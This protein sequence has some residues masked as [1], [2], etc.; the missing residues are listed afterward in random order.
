MPKSVDD[1]LNEKTTEAYGRSISNM[2]IRIR[3]KL[4]KELLEAAMGALP[5]SKASGEKST[6]EERMSAW[7]HNRCRHAMQS[8]LTKL[9]SEV[10]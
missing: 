3:D 6:V 2:N 7:S 5:P 8:A 9:F 4:K 1:I 10:R